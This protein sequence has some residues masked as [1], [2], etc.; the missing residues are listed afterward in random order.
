MTV[1]PLAAFV[2]YLFYFSGH[3]IFTVIVTP[4]FLLMAPFPVLRQRFIRGIFQWY[5]FFLSRRYLPSL[6]VYRVREISGLER[7]RAAGPAV[8]VVNHRSRMDGPLMLAT[9]PDAAVI[10]KAAYG[11]TILYSGFVKHL[12]FVSVEQG[13]LSSLAAAVQ[14][15][16]GL[17]TAGRSMIVFP[18]GTRSVTGRLLPFRDI[19]FRLARAAGVPIVPVVLQSDLPFMAKRPGSIFPPRTINFT[20]R[21]LEPARLQENEK[22]ESLV[23][24]VERAIA[25][26][27]KELD[28][29][30]V[31][32]TTE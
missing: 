32:E 20:M 23:E 8:Y 24:R 13:S 28:R 5:V 11:R 26:Q 10:I 30:T 22:L 6:G 1:T 14:R 31:W 17:L 15:A 25:A 4:L 29:G 12:D 9:V 21:F 19:A 7:A 3:V 2:G 27:L 18:E 16:Q